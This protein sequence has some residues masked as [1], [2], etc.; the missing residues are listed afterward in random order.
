M[1]KILFTT[2]DEGFTVLK[3][4]YLY[5]AEVTSGEFFDVMVSEFYETFDESQDVPTAMYAIQK[6]REWDAPDDDESI[7][8]AQIQCED[9]GDGEF[10]DY[11]F[12]NGSRVKPGTR[13][14]YEMRNT[15]FL[16][17]G[18]MPYCDVAISNIIEE[19]KDKGQLCFQF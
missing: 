3:D 11:I 16:D 9:W 2:V 8:Y 5:E 10:Q 14:G 17:E 6:V 15:L 4:L 13:I 19:R 18:I 7:P 12:F 1:K